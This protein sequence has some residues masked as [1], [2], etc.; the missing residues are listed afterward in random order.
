MLNSPNASMID[1]RQGR[2]LSMSIV[3]MGKRIR[4]LREKAGFTQAQLADLIGVTRSAISQIESG[5]T[6]GVRPEHLLA[7]A[8]HLRAPVEQIVHGTPANSSP[9]PEAVI[10]QTT[11]PYLATLTDGEVELLQYLRA[12]GG[13]NNARDDMARQALALLRA[14]AGTASEQRRPRH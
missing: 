4:T 2:L 8:Q 3:T 7:L 14:L 10:R 6:K 11:A 13:G 9:A 1:A 12:T 5:L